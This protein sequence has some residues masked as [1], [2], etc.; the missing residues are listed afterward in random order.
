VGG[1]VGAFGREETIEF[2]TDSKE[3]I[4]F[5]RSVYG[6]Q[7]CGPVDPL[8]KHYI[9]NA[10]TGELT[11]KNEKPRKVIKPRKDLPK[12]LVQIKN[13]DGFRGPTFIRWAAKKGWGSSRDIIREDW[14][15]IV[16]YFACC[17]YDPQ[18]FGQKLTVL[19]DPQGRYAATE[20]EKLMAKIQA[21]YD[22]ALRVQRKSVEMVLDRVFPNQ[23]SAKDLWQPEQKYKYFDEYRHL[24]D[25]TPRRKRIRTVFDRH[26]HL[27]GQVEAIRVV[28]QAQNER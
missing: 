25:W 23:W 11:L 21:L 10:A 22:P 15:T 13:E 12:S 24:R 28:L 7:I 17:G 18:Q 2:M 5:M 4:K 14:R 20:N 8:W 6:D 27:C 26:G 16:S 1:Q 19:F 9:E 3:R